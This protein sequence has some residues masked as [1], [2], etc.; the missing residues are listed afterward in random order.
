MCLPAATLLIAATAAASM[1]QVVSGIGQAQQYRQEAQIADRNR[2]LA[3]DQARDSIDNT[4][5]EAQ[6]RY[7]M[8]AQTQGSQQAS[9]AANGVDIDFGSA[10]DLQR[11]TAMIG[12]EDVTQIYKAG[13]ER[14]KGYDI[15]A[16]N[17]GNQASASRAK[18]SGA[19]VSGLFGAASTALGG[20]S[21]VSKMKKPTG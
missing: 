11:D 15:S 13:N 9:M 16:W 8:L 18:A 7:R 5:L 17:Y 12:A 10:L 4:N 2:A 19:I 3:N 1:G 21:Q 14:T 20:A 6:R